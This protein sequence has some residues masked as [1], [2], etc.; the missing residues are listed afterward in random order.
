MPL[1]CTAGIMVPIT[2][3]NIAATW[4]RVKV[5]ANRPVPVEKVT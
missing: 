4:L 5:E 2:V 1:N 3:R